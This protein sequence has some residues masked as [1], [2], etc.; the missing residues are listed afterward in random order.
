[1]T[2][3]FSDDGYGGVNLRLTQ[4]DARAWLDALQAGVYELATIR[5]DRPF[6]LHLRPSAQEWIRI[7]ALSCVIA[8]DEESLEYLRFRLDEFL[9]RGQMHSELWHMPD[10]KSGRDR[11][12]YL[13]DAAIP[14]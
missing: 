2:I 4:A 7:Q 5:E 6:A 9:R 12:V 11:W 1:M 10:I 13:F 14:A 8:V 3:E